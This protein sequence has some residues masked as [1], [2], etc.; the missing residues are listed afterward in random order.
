MAL[1]VITDTEKVDRKVWADFVSNHPDGSIFQMPWMYDLHQLI[2]FQRP[3]VFFAFDDQQMVGVM[4]A[5]NFKNSV[6]PLSW[7]TR[8]QIVFG[9]PLVAGHDKGILLAL[10]EHMVKDFGHK[11]VFS[12]IRNLRL[13]LSL[14]PAFEEAG[15]Y[16]ESY[17]SVVVDMNRKSGEMWE[18]LSPERRN[19]IGRLDNV[20]YNIRDLRGLQDMANVWRIIR[21]AVGKKGRPVPHRTLFRFIDELEMLQPFVRI[22]GFDVGGELKAVVVVMKFR[23]E[24]YFWIEGHCL[25]TT[26][27]WM[28]DGFLWNVIQE[29]EQEGIRF[30]DLGNGGRPGKDFLTRQYKKSYGGTIRETGRYI[31]VH[32]WVLWNLGRVFYR[33]YKHLRIFYYRNYCKV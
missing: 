14:K 19:N 22:K 24:A 33:W 17:L 26:S 8:R 29:L 31:Y 7:F 5:V 30:L 12:E 20:L 2:K 16:Y 3:V 15:F 1:R 10:L 21:C 25:N 32:N 13:G 4:V 27:E 9:G 11:A 28:Y 23:Q 6:F 18:S